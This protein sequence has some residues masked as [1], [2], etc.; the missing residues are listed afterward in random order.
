LILGIGC[1]T[2]GVRG[3]ELLGRE[4][5]GTMKEPDEVRASGETQLQGDSLERPCRVDEQTFGL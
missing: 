1:Q 4:S 3:A 2:M 5:G